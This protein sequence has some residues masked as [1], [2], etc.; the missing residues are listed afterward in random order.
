MTTRFP[1]RLGTDETSERGVNIV[2]T[3]FNDKF[4]WIFRRTHQ[5]HDF[6]IDA[7]IDLV[8]DDGRVTGKFIAAQIKTGKS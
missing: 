1:K 5:E 3:I 8:T 6:G 7:F 4:H 2:S